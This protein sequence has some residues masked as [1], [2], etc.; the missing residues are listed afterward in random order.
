MGYTECINNIQAYT[1]PP[2]YTPERWK[3]KQPQEKRREAVFLFFKQS[4]CLS[5]G[6]V[7]QDF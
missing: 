4:M 2:K 7:V 1:H 5:R 3:T 6:V